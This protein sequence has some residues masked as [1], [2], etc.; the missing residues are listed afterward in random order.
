MRPLYAVV[1]FHL[2]DGREVSDKSMTVES[3]N[4]KELSLVSSKLHVHDTKGVDFVTVALSYGN[5]AKFLFSVHIKDVKKVDVKKS[6]Y[7][8]FAPKDKTVK[9]GSKEM[10]VPCTSYK[11]LCS[12]IKPRTGSSRAWPNNEEELQFDL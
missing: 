6:S 3:I 9:V 5:V 10:I 2:K 8:F 11:K 4:D 12:M 1:T 7:V